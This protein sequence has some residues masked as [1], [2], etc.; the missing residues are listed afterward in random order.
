MGGGDFVI[1][2][3]DAAGVIAAAVAYCRGL[4]TFRLF[5]RI[6][7]IAFEGGCIRGGIL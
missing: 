1:C 6:D 4:R 3:W 7:A 5:F 2:S